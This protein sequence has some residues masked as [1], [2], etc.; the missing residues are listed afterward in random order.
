MIPHMCDDREAGARI[1]V[2]ED[3]ADTAESM[4]RILEL[5][6]H[7]VRIAGN[8]PQA[9]AVAQRWHPEFILLDLGLPAMDGYEVAIRLRREEWCLE[10]VIIAVTGHGQARDRQRSRE[11]GIDHHLLKPVDLEVLLSLLS[12]PAGGLAAH[13]V[14]KDLASATC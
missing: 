2:V 1:L 8:G 5:F 12:Q 13:A 11:S 14:T 4:A 10:T 6:D 7:A 9:I 3:N